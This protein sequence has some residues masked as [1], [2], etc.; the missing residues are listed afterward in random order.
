MSMYEP[1]NLEELTQ[2]LH[3]KIIYQLFSAV[4]V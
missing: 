1:E 4:I 2:R 3:M